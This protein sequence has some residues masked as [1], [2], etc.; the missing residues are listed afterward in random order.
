VNVRT[1]GVAGDGKSED[2]RVIQKAIEEHHVLYFPSGH[3][4][5]RD[6]LAL[7][8]DTVLIGL[9]PTLT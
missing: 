5:V 6:T 1:L 9:H 2:T 4:I 3:Y 8:P 7:K